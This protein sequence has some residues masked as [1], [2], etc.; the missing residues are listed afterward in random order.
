M[1]DT[2]N[3]LSRD[4]RP[5]APSRHPAPGDRR[6]PARSRHPAPPPLVTA[7]GTAS[8]GVASPPADAS[9]S[10]HGPVPSLGVAPGGVESGPPRELLFRRH[11]RVSV[12]LRQLVAAK[13]LVVALAERDFRARYKQTKVGVAWAVLTPLLLLGAFTILANTAADFDTNGVPYPLFAS[14][15]LVPWTFFS[16]AVATGSVSIMQN[17]SL[18]NKVYCP[19]EVFPLSSIATAAFDAGISLVLL[20]L[21]FI[22][23]R[24]GPTA[25]VV[26][27]PV[28]LVVQLAF[29]VGVT[30]VLSSLVVYLRDLRQ[31]LPLALQFALFATPVAYSFAQMDAA[32]RPLVSAVNP[33]APVIEGYRQTILFGEAPDWSLVGIAAAASTV[34][35]CGGYL[36]FKRLETG[37]ADVA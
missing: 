31:I 37:F 16:N 20:V 33:L 7:S 13:E 10:D 6:P 22:G 26:W 4:V 21:L 30:L 12:M 17:L 23:Y 29:T 15:A 35:L 3:H 9:R 27:V 34:W 8:D 2:P 32:W 11:L 5:S 24:Q 1:P 19:R 14:V 18:V 25:E 28:L 36:L